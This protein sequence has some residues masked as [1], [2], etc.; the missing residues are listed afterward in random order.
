[1]HRRKFSHNIYVRTDKLV[2]NNKNHK[3][4]GTR[5]QRVGIFRGVSVTLLESSPIY[6]DDELFVKIVLGEKYYAVK[7]SGTYYL[8]IP[9]KDGWAKFSI[10]ENGHRS[11]LEFR[12]RIPNL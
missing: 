6:V 5:K 3:N 1:M 8:V 2:F 4:N 7:H 10:C 11:K 12:L 9:D